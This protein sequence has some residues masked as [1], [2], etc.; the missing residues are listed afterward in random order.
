MIF[1]REDVFAHKVLPLYTLSI[2]VTFASSLVGLL[3]LPF[4]SDL[5]VLTVLA[6]LTVICVIILGFRPNLPLLMI[7]NVL[8]GFTLTSLLFVAN[9]ID[10]SIIP[11]AFGLTA[12]IFAIFSLISWKSNYNFLSWGKALFILL[13]VALVVTVVEIFV[14]SPWINIA[15]DLG[16]IVLFV[17]FV[18]YDTQNI[19]KRYSD[20]EYINACISLYLDFLNIFV[21]LV[22]ILL[23]RRREY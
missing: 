14:Q 9:V 7:F 3:F 15:V 19:L 12:L 17:G 13:I 6:V 1:T 22:D 8:E 21:R 2:I 20:N 16:I 5:I 4:L 10:P 23:R 18:L 11:E